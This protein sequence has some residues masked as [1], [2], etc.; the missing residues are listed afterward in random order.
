MHLVLHF[1]NIRM[2]CFMLLYWSSY[3][4]L[5]LDYAFCSYALLMFTMFMSASC[6]DTCTLCLCSCVDFTR[7]CPT[8]RNIFTYICR[9]QYLWLHLCSW[10]VMHV[11]VNPLCTCLCSWHLFCLCYSL[12]WH[13]STLP[14]S[15]R[16]RVGLVSCLWTSYS[17]DYVLGSLLVLQVH[18]SLA[19]FCLLVAP[20]CLALLC[21]L[22]SSR[23]C[24]ATNLGE[25]S[26][27]GFANL[28]GYTV[29]D[30]HVWLIMSHA[31]SCIIMSHDSILPSYDHLSFI[32][33]WCYMLCQLYLFILLDRRI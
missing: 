28:L 8:V 3:P 30:C 2:T 9:D 1:P 26:Q 16:L 23:P 18:G 5:C 33:N 6:W 32:L 29:K 10:Y 19:A 25:Y 24:I 15:A 21:F 22:L 4:I 14:Q 20:S 17:L 27:C 13:H 12:S 11:G 31:Y 7:L